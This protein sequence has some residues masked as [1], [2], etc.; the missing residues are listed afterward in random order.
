MIFQIFSC[1]KLVDYQLSANAV[2]KSKHKQ[3]HFAQLQRAAL[4]IEQVMKVR[5]MEA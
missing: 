4:E 3:I 5:Q 1:D 2:L